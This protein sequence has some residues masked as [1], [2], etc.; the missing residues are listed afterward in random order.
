[1]KAAVFKEARRMVVE[2]VPDPVAGPGEVVV[3]MKNVGI[4]GSDLHL[5]QYGFVPAGTIMGHEATGFIASVG[6]GVTEWKE[7]ERVLVRGAPCR[8]CERCLKYNNKFCLDPYPVGMGV[9]PG[10]YAEYIKVPT[11]LLEPIADDLGMR[12][13]ALMDPL[14]C[15]Q[16]GVARGRM[17]SGETLLVIGSG[18]IGL[19]LIH[20]LKKDG[21]EQIIL[22]EP[23]KRRAALAAELGADII[24][25]PTRVCVDEEVKKLTD[26]LGPEVVFECVGIPSTT[27]ES[28]S[29]VRR[30]G[31]VVWVGVCMEEISF[32]PLFW[33]L[34]NISI[35]LVMGWESVEKVPDYL[36]FIRAHQDEVRKAITDIIPLEDLPGTFERLANP[37]SE[38]KVMVEFD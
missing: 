25:D 37:N 14:G 24:L 17:Q 6:D 3:K 9:N 28:A 18:P 10:A 32:S 20:R 34:K 26:G 38:M 1:M 2:D 35:E 12:E 8:K 21:A 30:N 36:D 27:L 13:A 31:R 19:F 33:M 23:V 16:H 29:L 22:S 7:G 11:R 15:A 4:C 5:Y